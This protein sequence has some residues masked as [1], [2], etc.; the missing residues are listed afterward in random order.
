MLSCPRRQRGC[1][2]NVTV[3]VERHNEDQRRKREKIKK[4]KASMN[5][6]KLS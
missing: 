4:E 5:N 6:A 3:N 1:L 2:K